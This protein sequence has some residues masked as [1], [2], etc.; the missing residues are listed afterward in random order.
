[1]AFLL[2][3]P[4]EE[5]EHPES[6]LERYL[7]LPACH[8]DTDPLAWWKTIE[9]KYPVMSR[10]AKRFLSIPATSVRESFL[11]CRPTGAKATLSASSRQRENADIP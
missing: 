10:L 7:Y 11:H 4:Y 3:A 6:E 2:G 1:M 9:Q 8:L 5:E